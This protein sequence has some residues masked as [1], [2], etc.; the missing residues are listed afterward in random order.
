MSAFDLPFADEVLKPHGILS[1]DTTALTTKLLNYRHMY[2]NLVCTINEAEDF[3]EV[4]H[5]IIMAK[6][7]DSCKGHAVTFEDLLE[8]LFDVD[9]YY[10]PKAKKQRKTYGEGMKEDIE[11][12]TYGASKKEILFEAMYDRDSRIHDEQSSLDKQFRTDYGVPWV[13]FSNVC[14]EIEQRFNACSWMS[15]LKDV[16]LKLRIMDCLRQL[17]LG[18]PLG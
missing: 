12:Y 9:A 17:R 6:F 18:G 16:P 15:K 13:V 5:D 2:H 8:S 4:S 11:R 3:Y 14:N 7:D 10:L 1:T